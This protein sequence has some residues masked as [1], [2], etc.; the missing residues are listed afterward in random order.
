[1]YYY[2][3]PSTF[4]QILRID[5]DNNKTKKALKKSLLMH[6][7]HKQKSQVENNGSVDGVDV[8]EEN[9]INQLF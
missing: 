2:T 8:S 5:D 4:Q 9:N 6:V 7:P 3:A 1:V